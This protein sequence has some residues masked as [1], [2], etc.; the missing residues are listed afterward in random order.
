MKELHTSTSSERYTNIQKFDLI[1]GCL[2][3]ILYQKFPVPVV[4]KSNSI[5]L[6]SDYLWGQDNDEYQYKDYFNTSL[7]WL[8]KVGYIDY[9]ELYDIDD[10]AAV[11]SGLVLTAKALEVL[12][13]VPICLDSTTPL[14]DMLGEVVKDGAKDA[15]SS[16]V[17]DVLSMG[18]KMAFNYWGSGI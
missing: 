10:K 13:A 11:V 9:D 5:D 15:I 12:K 3:N 8:K 16:V 1:T 7:I 17:R 6:L 18:V 4:V 14:G 2:F